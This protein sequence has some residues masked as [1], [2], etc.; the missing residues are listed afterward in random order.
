MGGTGSFV[1]AI[2]VCHQYL[3]NPSEA[4]VE[5]LTQVAKKL[6]ARVIGDDGESYR[7]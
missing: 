7:W 3:Q 4:L 2:Y 5:K 1:Q 6:G